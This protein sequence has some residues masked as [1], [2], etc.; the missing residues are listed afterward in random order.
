MSSVPW[1]MDVPLTGTAVQKVCEVCLSFKDIS[2]LTPVDE[3]MKFGY[4]ML[5]VGVFIGIVL[6]KVGE[7][8]RV[9]LEK[10]KDS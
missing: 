6:P 8:C 7:Y 1:V 3:A 2:Q 4:F 9:L 10:R 5:A